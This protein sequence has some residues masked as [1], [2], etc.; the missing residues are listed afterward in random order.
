MAEAAAAGDQVQVPIPPAALPGRSRPRSMADWVRTVAGTNVAVL[1]LGLV[2]GV[3]SARVMG[4]AG[5]GVFNAVTVWLSVFSGLAGVGLGT[6][7]ISAYGRASD[8][9]RPSLA[10]AGILLVCL[11]GA[12]GSVGL[13]VLEPRLI[14]HLA[15]QAAAWARAGSP[16][17]F[18]GCVAGMCAAMLQVQARFGTMNWVQFVRALLY[19][20]GIV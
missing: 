12:L 7:F 20:V 15:P 3:I 2:T 16:L 6:A 10:R 1:A 19:A 9:D 18:L 5:K 8:A 11:W 14:G 17:V 4:P 13:Y